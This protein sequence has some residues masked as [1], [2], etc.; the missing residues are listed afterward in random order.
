MS[1]DIADGARFIGRRDVM[2]LDSDRQES[3]RVLA[4]RVWVTDGQGRDIV[5]GVGER[6]LL[7]RMGRV[8]VSGLLGSAWIEIE[9][10]ASADAA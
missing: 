4:G 10:K 6:V 8:V 1:N 9:A 5:I 3:L 7:A 2:V